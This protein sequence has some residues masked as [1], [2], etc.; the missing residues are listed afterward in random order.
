MSTRIADKFAAC[1]KQNRPA[2]GIFV[3]AGDP[4]YETGRAILKALP[5]AGAT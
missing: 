4:D 3:M 1:A 5:A 2:L